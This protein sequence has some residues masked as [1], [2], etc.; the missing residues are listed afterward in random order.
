[1]DRDEM[2]TLRLRKEERKMVEALAAADG[3]SL[4]DAIRMAVRQRHAERFP[5]KGGK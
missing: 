3:V 2:M 1:M 4:S 5:K